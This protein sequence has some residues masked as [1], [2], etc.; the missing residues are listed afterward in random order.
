MCFARR[1]LWLCLALLLLVGVSAFWA[2][3]RINSSRDFSAAQEAL[4]KRDF[5]LASS[6]LTK[7]IERNPED[8]PS[9]ILAARTARRE[10]A[11]LRA[12]DHLRTYQ[13]MGGS[14]ESVILEQQTGRPPAGRS[15]RGAA[16]LTYCREHPVA[17]DVFLILE[18]YVEGN[19][20]ILDPPAGSPKTIAPKDPASDSE[21]TWA[22]E[23]W[24][25]NRSSRADQSQGIYWQARNHLVFGRRSVCRFSDRA[26]KQTRLDRSS[27]AFCSGAGPD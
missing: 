2:I 1:K 24:F 8:L 16:F 15:D 20:K 11:L 9:R 22:L 17:P 10:G 23:W 18:A 27:F 3:P 13:E 12:F 26:R 14:K 7:Y 4:E 21:M 19:L 25:K 5:Q 6:F